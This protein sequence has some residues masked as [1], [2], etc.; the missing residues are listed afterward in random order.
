MYTDPRTTVGLAMYGAPTVCVHFR[1]S[2]VA[3]PGVI[4]LCN[5]A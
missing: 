2:F 1:T 5:L 3:L 4:A